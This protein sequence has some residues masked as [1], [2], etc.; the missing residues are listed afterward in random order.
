MNLSNLIGA[1][2]MLLESVKEDLQETI[3]NFAGNES[4]SATQ[5]RRVDALS[6]LEQIEPI[7][8][9]KE[10]VAFH[11]PFVLK[12]TH[13][14]TRKAQIASAVKMLEA[15]VLALDAETS[16]GALDAASACSGVVDL[17]ADIDV[18]G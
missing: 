14:R 8:L 3:D 18:P 11:V 12:A 2:E 17:L 16:Q 13:G 10:L 1:A 15:A 7:V 4:T 6:D 9:D 5:A